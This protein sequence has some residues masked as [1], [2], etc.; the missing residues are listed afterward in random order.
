M[1]NIRAFL[2]LVTATLSFALASP[3]SA[4]AGPADFTYELIGGG[5]AAAGLLALLL[6]A[7]RCDLEIPVF[8]PASSVHALL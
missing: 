7:S 2:I 5:V 1:S 3:A 6:L 4:D 8:A